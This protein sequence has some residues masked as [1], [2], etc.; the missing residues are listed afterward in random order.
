MRQLSIKKMKN[1]LKKAVAVR[2]P[3]YY[4]DRKL[5]ECW[6]TERAIVEYAQHLPPDTDTA[7][8]KRD[9]S[10]NAYKGWQYRLQFQEVGQQEIC[11]PGF[12]LHIAIN[13]GGQVFVDSEPW[14]AY[15]V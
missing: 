12:K 15:A 1:E 5:G 9:I 14:F 7:I 13:E 8:V 6:I 10:I 3:M 11:L 4:N 2:K